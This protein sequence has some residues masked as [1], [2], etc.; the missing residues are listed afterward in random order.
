MVKYMNTVRM[1]AA[2]AGVTMTAGAVSAQEQE[3]Y[4]TPAVVQALYACK[5]I[6]SDAER[7]KCFEAAVE[8]IR[9]A[10]EKR[11]LSF[12]DRE[13]VKKAKRGLF[14]L[15]NIRLGI[16]SRGDNDPEE[17]DIQ[18]IEAKVLSISRQKD[19]KLLLRLEGGSTWAQTGT[20]KIRIR[21]MK[22]QTVK[23]KKGTLGSYVAI[24]DGGSA[25]KVKRVI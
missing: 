20:E 5:D 2:V 14:G 11:D 8:D 24:L 10:E 4:R 19:G 12:A 7:L 15:G 3:T 17:Q 18:E 6:A 1:V 23:I 22:A 13:Q 21:E 9:K 25:I 16:F